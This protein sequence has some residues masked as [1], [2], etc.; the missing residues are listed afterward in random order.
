MPRVEV[1]AARPSDAESMLAITRTV[2]E[3]HDYVPLVWNRWL[4]DRSGVLMTASIDEEVVGLQHV[5]LQPDGDAW[6]EGIRVAEGA[7]GR[8]VGKALVDRGVDWARD[9]GCAVA[10]MAVS[11]DNG[12][13][14]RLSEKAGFDIVSRFDTMRAEPGG[15]VTATSVRIAQPFEERRVLDLMESAGYRYPADYTEGWT[16]YRLTRERLRLLLATHAVLIAGTVGDEAVVIATA[17]SERPSIRVGL[18]AGTGAGIRAAGQWLR[19]RADEARLGSVRGTLD[20]APEVLEAL[21]AA[22]FS[23]GDDAMLLRARH[24]NPV[25]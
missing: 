10:R 17:S 12:P 24:L 6:L 16:A 1:R 14:N 25:P 4:A 22:G 19:T 23:R 15:V 3:G 7:R 20:A 13:S 5:G 8:G 2:W 18:A 9:M 11:S 21:G